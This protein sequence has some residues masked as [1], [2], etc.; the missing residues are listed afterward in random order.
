MTIKK[1]VKDLR[2]EIISRGG[3]ISSE[4]KSN[5]RVHICLGMKKSFLDLIDL[6]VEER[7]GLNRTAWI[8]EAIQEKLKREN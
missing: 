6:K 7:I 1:K 3:E 8:L 4:T 5:D 2:E